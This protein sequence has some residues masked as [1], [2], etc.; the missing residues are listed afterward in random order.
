[1]RL[2]SVALLSLV[3]TA[4]AA[5]APFKIDFEVRRG[6]SKDDLSPEDDSNPRFVKRD[7]SLDMTFNQQTDFLY[8]HVEN[9]I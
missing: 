7:G 4:L 6:E 5:K 3:A 8:G 1:M 9:W 2:N